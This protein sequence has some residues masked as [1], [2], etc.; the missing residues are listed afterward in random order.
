[1]G[2][3]RECQSL[4]RVKSKKAAKA[5]KKTLPPHYRVGGEGGYAQSRD[6]RATPG[7]SLQESW[8]LRALVSALRGVL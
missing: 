7:K 8:S 2:G 6:F 3:G 5:A 4:Y 1:M